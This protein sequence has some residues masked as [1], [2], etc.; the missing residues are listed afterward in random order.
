MLPEVLQTFW[1]A[2][3]RG[4]F[5]TD[6]AA[7]AGTYRKKGT[8]WLAAAGG[9]RP[10]R[11]RDLQGRYLSFAEREEIALARAGGESMRSIGA[12]LGRSPSTISRELG[13]NRAPDA[14]GYRVST[15]HALAYQ[16]ASRPKPA[17]LATNLALRE[18]VERDLGKKY[19]PEQIAG[20]L[21][22]E[23]PDQ[24]EMQ[25]SHETIC[26]CRCGA[27]AGRTTRLGA[28]DPGVTQKSSGRLGVPSR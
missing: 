10:R 23:F 3:Q 8:R 12:R 26:E 17:K 9:V 22:V 18:H 5:I 4:E 6:A 11:G 14:G 2:L 27:P 15:A 1:A 24:P 20:R 25:V 7:E 13:R 19:S 21:R 28:G 16:R